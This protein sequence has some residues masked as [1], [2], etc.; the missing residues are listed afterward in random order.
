MISVL[1]HLIAEVILSKKCHTQMGLI[2]SGY[3]VLSIYGELNETD[4]KKNRLCFY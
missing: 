2:H 3:Q 4:V 1:K